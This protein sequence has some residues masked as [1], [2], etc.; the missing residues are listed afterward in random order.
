MKP[1]K[2]SGIRRLRNENTGRMNVIKIMVHEVA[3]EPAKTRRR[4]VGEFGGYYPLRFAGSGFKAVVPYTSTLE[5]AFL[6]WIGDCSALREVVSRPVTVVGSFSGTRRIY[7]P[8][9]LVDIDPVPAD[10]RRLNF[11][12][13]TFVECKPE[14]FRDNWDVKL[15]MRMLYLATGLPVVLVTEN[16]IVISVLNEEQQPFQH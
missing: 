4:K 2:E 8:S 9:Y 16:T 11:G 7:T 1:W 5:G 10:L 13:R 12:N 15:T 14:L 6:E 3:F